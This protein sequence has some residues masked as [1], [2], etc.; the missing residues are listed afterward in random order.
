[1]YFQAVVLLYFVCFINEI[2][3]IQKCVYQYN[4]KNNRAEIVCTNVV[5]L[6][7]LDHNGNIILTGKTGVE[8]A[9]TPVVFHF[10][11]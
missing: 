11:R 3:S 8:S 1:M 7:L 6:Q 2:Q 9:N 5:V 10:K 4:M